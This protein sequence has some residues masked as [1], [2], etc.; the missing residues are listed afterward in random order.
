MKKSSTPNPVF[1]REQKSVTPAKMALQKHDYAN[2]RQERYN[3]TRLSRFF[4]Y[5][6]ELA[7]EQTEKS[8]R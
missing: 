4:A 8:T 5:L 2:K 3:I 1:L 6:A 7:K